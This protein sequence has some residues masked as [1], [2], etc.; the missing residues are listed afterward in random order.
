M[1]GSPIID[2]ASGLMLMYLIV[3]LFCTVIQEWIARFAALRAKN[4]TAA[5]TYML[6]DKPGAMSP[7]AKA[8]LEHPLVRLLSHDGRTDGAS[9]SY[10]PA[11]G[12]ATALI[13]ALAPA[14]DQD[15][16]ITFSALHARVEQIENAELK[17]AL[18]SILATSDGTLDRAMKGIEFWFDATMDRATGWYKRSTTTSL[19]WLG[20]VVALAVNADTVQVAYRLAGD[21][22]LADRVATYA[23][24]LAPQGAPADEGYRK[25]ADL[26]AKQLEKGDAVGAL[27]GLPI[28]WQVC[29]RDIRRI[30]DYGNPVRDSNGKEVI[31]KDW[32][33][34]H[35]Y[36]ASGKDL[37]ACGVWAFLAK[38]FGV[39]LTGLMASLGGPFWFGLLQ[40]LNA[41]RASGPKPAPTQTTA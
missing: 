26:V 12:F 25:A 30:D 36:D 37:L 7:E 1:T 3:S 13:A 32:S 39:L 35:C 6:A 5:I 27:G 33:L 2:V 24:V 11:S 9:P 19:F 40:S 4:L 34:A 17:K 8:V 20:I 15:G 23:A 38:C 22:K 29:S 41:I 14:R 21:P 31:V 10:L 18:A 28:G 16:R